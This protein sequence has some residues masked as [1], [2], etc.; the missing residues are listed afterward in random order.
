MV[1]TKAKFSVLIASHFA[2]LTLIATLIASH[3]VPL[4]PPGKL[5]LLSTTKAK[6]KS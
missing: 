4:I 6:Q 1:H 2:P 3:F 5:N